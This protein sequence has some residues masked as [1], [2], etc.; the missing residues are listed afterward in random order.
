MKDD[1]SYTHLKSMKNGRVFPYTPLLANRGDM[2]PCDANGNISEG[3]QGDAIAAD[4]K[5]QRRVTPFLGNLKNGVLYPYTKYLAERSDMIS[6]DTKEQW[7][8]MKEAGKAPPVAPD[9]VA[10]VLK[11]PEKAPETP[12]QPV[13]EEASTGAVLINEDLPPPNGRLVL[14]D[15]TGLGNRDAK[16]VLA[17]WSKEYY[18]HA[19]DR[20]PALSEVLA[21]CQS[22]INAEMAKATA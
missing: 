12:E 2:L 9:T 21:E 22:L 18:G 8:S 11:R 6:I 13:A 4:A 10:P 1:N 15:I 3:H 7:E 19:L 16:T 17:A 20:R 5:Q 14:P